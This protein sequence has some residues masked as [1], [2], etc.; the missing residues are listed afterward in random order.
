MHLCPLLATL[1]LTAL[2][3]SPWFKPKAKK[4][5]DEATVTLAFN[6][7]NCERSSRQ[8]Q[9]KRAACHLKSP[10]Q[11]Q[12]VLGQVN[13]IDLSALHCSC[14]LGPRRVVAMAASALVFCYWPRRGSLPSAVGL[15]FFF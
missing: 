5:Q 9:K 7:G 10:R 4:T 1:P 6:C 2:M 8:R 15:V 14:L 3:L 13:I 11:P 12:R